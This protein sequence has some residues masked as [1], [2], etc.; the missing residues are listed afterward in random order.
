MTSQDLISFLASRPVAILDAVTSVHGVSS[1]R[2][3]ADSIIYA[4]THTQISKNFASYN[5]RAEYTSN[6]SLVYQREIGNVRHGE[7]IRLR[8][9]KEFS[10]DMKTKTVECSALLRSQERSL[11]LYNVWTSY[12]SSN[13]L[14]QLLFYFKK[15][16]TFVLT[17]GSPHAVT[18]KWC[19]LGNRYCL[20]LYLNI[21]TNIE[22]M[23]AYF[24]SVLSDIF[25]HLKAGCS[26]CKGCMKTS[27]NHHYNPDYSYTSRA[28]KLIENK[29]NI[30][31]H[32]N[33]ALPVYNDVELLHFQLTSILT[34]FVFNF[35]R[36]I[37]LHCGVT[38]SVLEPSQNFLSSE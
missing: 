18:S 22:P 29:N 17:I 26:S 2:I 33:C 11:F 32:Y 16:I 31:N 1:L 30:D 23:A 27:V 20:S 37:L 3:I 24:E 8:I 12:S 5:Q 36:I 6:T 25:H 13:L 7:N 21:Q 15:F 4:Y 9:S 28:L 14:L 19:D 38:W 10:C 35:L 34:Y